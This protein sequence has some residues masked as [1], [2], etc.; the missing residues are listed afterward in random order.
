MGSLDSHDPVDRLLLVVREPLPPGR[1]GRL[2][3]TRRLLSRSRHLCTKSVLPA[4]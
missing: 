3:C 4:A 2:L 1:F